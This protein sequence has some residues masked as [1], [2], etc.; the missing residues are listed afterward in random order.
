MNRTK[1]LGLHTIGLVARYSGLSP[2]IIRAWETRYQAVTPQRAANGRRLYSDADIQRL[3]LLAR[4]RKSGR[5]IGDIAQLSDAKLSDLI[6]QD[7]TIGERVTTYH[8][9]QSTVQMTDYLDRCV[10]SVKE[11][12]FH[13]LVQILIRAEKS[14]GTIFLIEDLLKP[15]ITH[16]RDECRR[17]NLLSVHHGSFLQ[18]VSAYLIML[19]TRPESG[20]PNA[21]VYALE[22][23]LEYCG[24]MSSA[25]MTVCGWRTIYFD[26]SATLEG[27][28]DIVNSIPVKVV[29]FV[30]NG[31]DENDDA[32]NLIR[33]L[34]KREPEMK[35][36]LYAPRG[37][38]YGDTIKETDTTHVQSFSALRFELERLA[39]L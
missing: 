27:I 6:E 8:Q 15:L 22:N 26:P 23:D 29:I 1:R 39:L 14:L 17:G 20:H 38:S 10:E 30:T 37:H 36:I 16:I 24:L 4:A 35:I 11:F 33:Q 9:R 25:M 21:I 3:T 19:H 7:E 12:D 5:R 34:K 32:P 13:N 28:I 18:V 2:E 31:S